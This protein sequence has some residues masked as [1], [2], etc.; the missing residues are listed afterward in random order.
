MNN[1]REMF[2]VRQVRRRKARAADNMNGVVARLQLLQIP[3]SDFPNN[4]MCFIDTPGRPKNPESME[5]LS[6]GSSHNKTKQ[7]LDQHCSK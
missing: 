5:M 2:Q 6:L 4:L 1:V 3:K 7:K